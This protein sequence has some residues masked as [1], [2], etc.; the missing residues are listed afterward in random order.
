MTKHEESL[1]HTILLQN[2]IIASLTIDDR[3]LSCHAGRAVWKAIQ[4]S[5][6]RNGVVDINTLPGRGLDPDYLY[7]IGMNNSVPATWKHFE[8]LVKIDYKRAWMGSILSQAAD[9]QAGLIDGS[10]LEYLEKEVTAFQIEAKPFKTK[11]G[12]E[13]MY[14]G[15]QEIQRRYDLK[16]EL[17]GMSCGIDAIDEMTQGFQKRL[18]YIVGARPSQGKTALAVTLINNMLKKYKCGF[19]SAESSEKE[20]SVRM[21]S[22][23]ASVDSNRIRAGMLSENEM[24]RV[25]DSS[26]KIAGSGFLIFDEPNVR[27]ETIERTARE[28]TRQDKL[29]IML[30]DY[31]Q[32]IQGGIGDTT[33]EKL[34]NISTRVKGLARTL[35]IPVILLAQ[36]G[37]GQGDVPHMGDLKGS[38]QFE[39]DADCVIL[40]YHKY[41]DD[42]NII[43]SYINFDKVR[44][45]RTGI[46]QVKFQGEYT[47]FR[48]YKE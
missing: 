22:N 38:G 14:S 47:R 27:M 29:D 36:N 5:Y 40:P 13:V 31:C 39:Q 43:E 48:D 34:G 24:A 19:F 3:H 41:D 26:Q 10:P 45:G 46:R 21:I 35:D 33:V 42:G 37:R 32:I 16:G 9:M 6:D 12:K 17:P 15:I 23:H 30:I 1:F 11:T 44:D 7:S 20:I 18:L 8:D 2:S 4:D 28:W 25:M